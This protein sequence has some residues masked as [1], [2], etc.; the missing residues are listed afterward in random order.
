MCLLVISV[1]NCLIS[2]LY[3][4]DFQKNSDATIFQIHQLLNV[5][6]RTLL[7]LEQKDMKLTKEYGR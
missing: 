5:H 2:W 1:S 6:S 7:C 3:D 4:K